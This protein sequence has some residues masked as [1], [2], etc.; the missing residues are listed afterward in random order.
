M[1]KVISPEV[2]R[3]KLFTGRLAKEI[4]KFRRRRDDVFGVEVLGEP[5]WDILLGLYAAECFH[6]R[7]SIGGACYLSAVP[8][9]TALRWIQKLEK[10]ALIRR[11]ADPTDARMEWLVLT[12]KGSRAMRDCLSLLPFRFV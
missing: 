9:S 4:L 11:S 3:D 6:E 1:P 5:A 2:E 10:D 12:E 8:E 7:I